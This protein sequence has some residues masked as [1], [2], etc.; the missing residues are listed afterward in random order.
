M[1]AAE[2]PANL[3]LTSVDGQTRTMDEWLITFQMLGVVLDPFTYESSWILETAGRI[4][5]TTIGETFGYLF[6]AVWTMLVATSLGEV[7]AGRAFRL[8]GYVSAAAIGLGVFS[9]LDLAVIDT[10][11]F[12]GYVLWSVWLVWMAVVLLR[13]RRRAVEPAATQA[14][15]NRAR[16]SS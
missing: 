2:V 7:F 16:M 6:T 8:V 3:Q 11:N 1:A 12:G 5:G 14:L 9:P 10:V 4:L 13:D 15:A